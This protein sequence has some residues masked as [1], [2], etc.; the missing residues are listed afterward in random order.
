M[1]KKSGSHKTVNTL[2]TE[3][4]T[5]N[6]ILSR[7]AHNKYVESVNDILGET[8]G[9][10]SALFGGT[11]LTL[12]TLIAGLLI[13]QHYGYEVNYLFPI[14]SFPIGFIAGV[15]IEQAYRFLIK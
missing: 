6:K 10:P 9:R 12:T 15:V 14:L 8:I 2:H 13:N 3:L 11:L 5:G 4:S 7:F 1:S